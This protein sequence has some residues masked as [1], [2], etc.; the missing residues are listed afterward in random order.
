M[1]HAPAQKLW[2]H[3]V[4]EAIVPVQLVASRPPWLAAGDPHDYSV[5]LGHEAINGTSLPIIMDSVPTGADVAGVPGSGAGLV[6]R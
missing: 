6:I 5:I 3:L 4:A 2:D 1:E